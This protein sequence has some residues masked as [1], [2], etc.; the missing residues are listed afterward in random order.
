MVVL[1]LATLAQAT[2]FQRL[3]WRDG[4]SRRYPWDATYKDAYDVATELP[5]RPIYL[6]DG[7]W[8]PG[9]VHALWYATLEGRSKTEFVHLPYRAQPPAGALVLSSAEKCMDCQIL[10]DNN[11]YK[12]YR[13]L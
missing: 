4:Y 12:V 6:E 3:F 7:K 10:F 9:Y 11:H 1:V 2:Y 5:S 8:G 13:K